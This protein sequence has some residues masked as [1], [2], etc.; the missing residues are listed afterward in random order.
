VTRDR[1]KASIPQRATNPAAQ[2]PRAPRF[3]KEQP[4]KYGAYR[5][6]VTR[7]VTEEEQIS[8]ECYEPSVAR[9]MDTYDRVMSSMRDAMIAHNERVV[10]VHQGHLQKLDRMIERRAEQVRELDTL[11]EERREWLR[12]KGMDDSDMPQRENG[13]DE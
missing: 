5:V 1:K 13:A 9:A 3:G 2:F 4:W 6:V 7:R 11:C 12:S 10:L 8:V